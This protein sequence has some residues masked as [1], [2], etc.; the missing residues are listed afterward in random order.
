VGFSIY[1]RHAHRVEL[2]LYEHADSKQPLRTIALEPPVHRTWNYWHA[3]VGGIG[4]GQ[5]YAYRVHGP[6]DP[7]RGHRFD[8]TKLLLDPYGRA[9]AVP[10]D[11]R[12]D[13]GAG[14][15]G[16][17]NDA[18]ACKS[19]VAD[20]QAYDWQGDRPLRRPFAQTLIYEMH[21][22]G[23][24]Q[25]PSSGVPA[26]RRGCFAGVVDKIPYLLDLGVT[27]VELMPVFQFDPADAPPGRRNYW[28]YAPISFFAPHAGYAAAATPLAV[29]DEFRDMVRALHRAGLEVILDV[30]FN[31][32][33]EGDERGPTFGL[34]GLDNSTYYQLD[35]QGRPANF[36]G[37]G[38]TL[39][40]NHAVVRRLIL[41]SLRYWVRVMHVDGFRFD[42]ASILSRDEYGHPV[43]NPPLLWD[44]ESD[45]VLAGTKLI[46]EA[47]DAAGL[48]QVGR[49]FGERWKEWNGQFRDDVRSF[50]RG[51]AGVVPR[52]ADR[53]L[54]SP[55]LYGARPREPAQSIN[56]V[57]SHDGFTLEDLVSY[58]HKHNEANGEA[59]RDGSDD[60]RSWN[61][62][63][64]GPTDDAQ[65]LALR[66]RQVKNLLAINLLSLGTPM[67]LMGDEMRRSQQGNNNAYCQDDETSWLD[68]SLLERHA[69]IHRFVRGLVRIRNL[70]ESVRNDHRLTLAEL[71]ERV[72][73]QLHGVR[74][75]APDRTEHSR[76]LAI[77]ATSLS[78]DLLMHFALNAWWEPL[79]FELPALPADALTGWR[80]I[81]DSARDAP[82]DLADFEQAQGVTGPTHRVEARS[83]VVLFAQLR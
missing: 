81:I 28:G 58:D 40:A 21:V 31:H 6:W 44:I 52:L 14:I 53:L 16:A 25:H 68:W 56:F 79:P 42:L 49:F 5:V 37:C 24:T 57:T 63:V 46:A 77:T 65:V 48:Y 62:G 9:V 43:A 36:S 34:R 50:V 11:W 64:E 51:D 76:S 29:L 17:P 33:A 18:H 73:V 78:G 23:F 26:P 3:F 10:S 67:L 54:G 30:V 8:P 4:P 19:V 83:V 13:A 22:R 15:G 75:G 80:R 27:A 12:R 59:N 47:W 61:C 39:N 41:D 38:N 66:K 1:S 74:L 60:N 71:I 72:N 32:T 45:P 55:D 82:H 7:A 70:R 20:D 2:L 35:R 69:D